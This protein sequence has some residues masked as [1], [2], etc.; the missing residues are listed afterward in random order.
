MSFLSRP[1]PGPPPPPPLRYDPAQ[2]WGLERHHLIFAGPGE[3]ID[4]LSPCGWLHSLI[5]T[6]E[7]PAEHTW[8]IKV[9]AELTDPAGKPLFRDCARPEYPWCIDSWAMQ[10]EEPLPNL[11]MAHPYLVRVTADEACTVSV[12]QFFHPMAE[13]R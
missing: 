5:F 13:G 3:M 4:Y 2:L 1:R 8:L 6:M 9:S 7:V 11:N 12:R 10:L